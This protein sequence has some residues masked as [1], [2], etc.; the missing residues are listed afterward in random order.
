MI[1]FKG[2]DL[3]DD[4]VLPAFNS[5]TTNLRS[6][7]SPPQLENFKVPQQV[8]FR[9]RLLGNVDTS[10]PIST[11]EQDV[12]TSTIMSIAPS[13]APKDGK[14][15]EGQADSRVHQTSP[16]QRGNVINYTKG[17]IN[18]DGLVSVVDQINF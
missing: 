6:Y 7:L 10:T 14:T 2:G 5:T 13:Y 12:K 18:A 1:C 3:K 8:D 11:F 15:L 4:N 16:G 17:K 9:T